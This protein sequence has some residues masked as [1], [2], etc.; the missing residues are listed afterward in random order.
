MTISLIMNSLLLGVGLAMDAF[1]VSLANGLNNKN[2]RVSKQFL[3]AGIF[4]TLQAV[5]PMTGWLIV[6]KA[7]SLLDIC[8]MGIPWVSAGV[9]VLVS[10]KMILEGVKEKEIEAENIEKLSMC[11]MII[12]GVAT[13]LDALS[14]GFTIES[15]S[16]PVA[17]VCSLIIAIIT[18]LICFAG[19]SIGRRFGTKLAGKSEIFGGII[20][21]VIAVEILIKGLIG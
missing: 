16:F 3:I 21:M 2:M 10:I 6:S 11:A 14:V 20:L 4:A 13:S 8:K 5:M 15:Y 1:S 12:Q 7:V 9:L 18:F 17:L 19:V